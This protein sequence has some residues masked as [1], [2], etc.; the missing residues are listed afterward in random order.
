M[1]RRHSPGC[2]CCDPVIECPTTLTV[3]VRSRCDPA[4]A[5]TYISGATVTAAD[6]AGVQPDVTDTTDADGEAILVLD[7]AGGTYDVTVT[8]A[9]G[10][11]ETVEGVVVAACERKTLPDVAPCCGELCVEVYDHDSGLAIAGATVSPF[12]FAATDAAGSACVTPFANQQNSFFGVTATGYINA[13][14]TLKFCLPCDCAPLASANHP[15]SMF[16]D[17]VYVL[18]GVRGQSY[19]CTEEADCL[20]G[21]TAR[22]TNVFKLAMFVDLAGPEAIFGS[23]STGV[24]V[25][26][27]G[28]A[29]DSD[30]GAWVGWTTGGYAYKV[31]RVYSEA[32]G[33]WAET[34][35]ER[36]DF[37]KARVRVVAETAP[38]VN[39]TILQWTNYVDSG[40]AT[41]ASP[42]YVFSTSGTP[43]TDGYTVV[44]LAAETYCTGGVPYPFEIWN[45]FA[46]SGRIVLFGDPEPIT[47]DTL[48]EFRELGLVTSTAN[49]G[50][51]FKA[52]NFGMCAPVDVSGAFWVGFGGYGQCTEYDTIPSATFALYE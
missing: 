14:G 1:R 20:L 35:R 44:A 3:R 21:K 52:F 5:T 29:A 2:P 50:H 25:D 16:P 19:T 43:G 39:S 51:Y 31:T 37:P 11:A 23:A 17:S 40:G 47:T 42:S 45:G 9:D 8:L 48:T 33:T 30:L 27:D 49:A 46:P 41:P 38:D 28:A 4:G 18:A 32:T 15:V 7:N 34:A 13:R 10:C 12:G 36:F 24:Q 22:P 6:Q 26:W